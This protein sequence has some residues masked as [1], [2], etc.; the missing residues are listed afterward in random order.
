M[1]GSDQ[2]LGS[3]KKHWYSFPE[4]NSGFLI[5]TGTNVTK[6]ELMEWTNIFSPSKKL[7]FLRTTEKGDS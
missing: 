3:N 6:C 4:D 1:N 5:G 7:N 2:N